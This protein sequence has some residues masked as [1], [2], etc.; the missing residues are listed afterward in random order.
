[1]DV[2][3]KQRIEQT[4]FF[5]TDQHAH[6][7]DLF[8][9]EDVYIYLAAL[10]EHGVNFFVTWCRFIVQLHQDVDGILCCP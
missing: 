6:G 7:S 3:S 2:E 10:L 5:A 4:N 9:R 8:V 1:M